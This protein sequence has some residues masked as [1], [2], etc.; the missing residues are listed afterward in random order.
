MADGF[1]DKQHSTLRRRLQEVAARK[2]RFW[3]SG[4]DVIYT[5]DSRQKV[6]LQG[7]SW[8]TFK[9]VEGVLGSS[10]PV[11]IGR[12]SGVHPTTTMIPGS[13]HQ[14]GWVGIL[15]AHKGPNGEW[16]RADHGIGDRGPIVIGNDCWVGYEAVILSGVHIGD[17][18]IVAARALVRKDVEP[19]AIVGGNPGKVIGYRFEEPVREALLRIRWWDWSDEKVAAHGDQIHSPE[20]AAFV[21]GHDPALGD[22]SCPVCAKR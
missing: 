17:G 5:G 15:H 10:T 2:V 22:P 13:E 16:V 19:Y 7:P 3:I 8:P 11:T 4:H 21:A 20:V 1:G 14:P 9:V 12:Y 18:A 6:V